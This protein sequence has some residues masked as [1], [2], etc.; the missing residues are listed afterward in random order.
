MRQLDPTVAAER[1]RRVLQWVVHHYIETSRPIAS[2]SI[3]EAGGLELSS[4]T[5]RNILKELED[6]GFLQQPHTSAGRIPT[7]RGYRMYVD[8]LHDV[9]R[10]ASNEKASIERQYGNRLEELDRLLLQTS[11]VLSH[12]SHKTGLVLSPD[13]DR[14]TL[15]RLELIPLGHKQVLA[16]V[17]TQT[18]Q[19]RHWP[20]QL[21]FDPSADRL[22][23]LNR[24]LNDHVLG[25][26][27]SEVRR[28]LTER[29]E[30]AERELRELHTL[31]SQLLEE[32][33]HAEAPEKLFLDGTVSLVD[34]SAELGDIAD[35]QS[36]MRVME[37]RKVIARLL[38]DEVQT[39]AS[40]PD[41]ES[42]AV[43]VRIGEENAIPELKNLSLVTTVYRVGGR[44]VGA[45][46]VLGGKR[47]EYSRMM[48]LVDYVGRVVSRTLEQWEDDERDGR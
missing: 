43:Q 46:G 45:L 19:V 20:I 24:F 32:I 14:Q 48:S 36:L 2:S 11:K 1:K 8:Y 31:A 3:A 35:I 37:E 42:K 4:A 26:S 33:D 30:T 5:I 34:D 47:M 13:F 44:P 23:V 17:V 27:I 12:L 10:L 16:I 40:D 38:Q 22:N 25:R 7:D 29:I 28:T 15:K 6:E 41:A 9:Q 18:G 21:S 39:A